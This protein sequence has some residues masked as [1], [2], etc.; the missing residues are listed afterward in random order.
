MNVRLDRHPDEL[1][2]TLEGEIDLANVAL[3]DA[4]IADGI[5]ER[6]RIVIDLTATSYIDSAGLRMLFALART[7]GERLTIVL[8]ETS[9]LRRVVSMVGLTKVATLVDSLP[10]RT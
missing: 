10:G 3:V 9:P 1:V 2:F 6:S 4:E 8:P 5:D 7:V